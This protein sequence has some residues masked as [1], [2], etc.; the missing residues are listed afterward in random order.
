MKTNNFASLLA[1]GVGI[2]TLTT[3]AEAAVNN[4]FHVQPRE[5]CL[6]VCDT[7]QLSLGSIHQMIKQRNSRDIG[8]IRSTAD[9]VAHL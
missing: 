6:Q 7:E 3:S 5:I 2:A 1:A 4:V 8:L 9:K